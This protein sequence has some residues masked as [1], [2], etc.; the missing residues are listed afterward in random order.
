M[1][2]KKIKSEISKLILKFSRKKL[3]KISTKQ[4]IIGDLLDSF[5]MI[6]FITEFEKK[7]KIKLNTKD[8]TPGNFETLSNI[9]K[10]V[11]KNIK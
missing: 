8:L 10:L 11:K 1:S 2:E 5:E 4:L 6:N 7:F 3:K 9:H